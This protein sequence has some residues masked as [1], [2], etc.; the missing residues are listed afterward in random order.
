LRLRPLAFATFFVWRLRTGA[1]GVGAY[2][3]Y[4]SYTVLL[5]RNSYWFRR[6]YS[7]NC[8]GK[9]VLRKWLSFHFF[10]NA[11]LVTLTSTPLN[12]G[13][14]LRALLGR[15]ASEK[16]TMLLPVGYPAEDATVPDLHRKP[17]EEILVEVWR[18]SAGNASKNTD[19]EVCWGITH[20]REKFLLLRAPWPASLIFFGAL[21]RVLDFRVLLY[22]AYL[23]V[24]LSFSSDY[25]QKRWCIF[26]YCKEMIQE[27][28]CGIIRLEVAARTS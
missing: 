22:G 4:P 27:I 20:R 15:P 11:G 13:P 1:C 24:K 23:I 8:F 7:W 21:F 26:V 19:N 28:L 14:A 25:H 5:R 16:L 10:Q 3:S 17:L 12:C 2:D 6:D 18:F 9:S